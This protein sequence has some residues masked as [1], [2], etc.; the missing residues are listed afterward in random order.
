MKKTF[1][2]LIVICVATI[3]SAQS[4]AIGFQLGFTEPI[5]RLNNN[6][7]TTVQPKKTVTNGFKIGFIYDAT[8]I[9]GFGM[10]MGL[11][12]SLSAHTTS[13]EAVDGTLNYETKRSNLLQTI[14]IPIDWQ[15]KF[16]VAQ[17]TYII[18]F[19]GPTIQY[20]FYF[21][22]K[23]YS[24]AYDISGKPSEIQN[25]YNHYNVNI[26]G[27]DKKDFTPFNIQW[28]IGAGLQYDRYYIRGSY[29]FG[30]YNHFRD[31]YNETTEKYNRARLDQWTIRLG[32]YLWRQK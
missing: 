23:D 16:E 10:S 17:N 7:V 15:Y 28:G 3:A 19:T 1:S 24:K 11:N 31:G 27:D 2:L 22:T 4:Q 6:S 8:L 30:I 25:S 13:W 29:D 26:D 20:N 12:Y 14:E 32:I 5:L 9:K 21:H 18:L